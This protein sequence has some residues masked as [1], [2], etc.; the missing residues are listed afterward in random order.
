MNSQACW[1]ADFSGWAS[2]SSLIWSHTGS[3]IRFQNCR[4]LED[5]GSN[6][7]CASF[8]HWRY[9]RQKLLRGR[10]S[11]SGVRPTG[12]AECSTRWMISRSSAGE[13]R[14]TSL[15]AAPRPANSLERPALERQ[16]RHELLELLEFRPHLRHTAAAPLTFGIPDQAPLSGLQEVLAPAEGAAWWAIRQYR[17]DRIPSCRQRATMLVSP[18]KPFTTIRTFSTAKYFFR[19]SRRMARTVVSAL[20][21][22]SAILFPVSQH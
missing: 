4:P 19:V 6:P 3:G 11:S 20:S 1:R 13:R 18:G 17:F 2:A 10:S 5:C 15:T 7:F 22:I 21:C 14:I 16:L 12:K 8:W 9:Q